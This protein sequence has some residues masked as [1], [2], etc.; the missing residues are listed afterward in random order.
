MDRR[1]DRGWAPTGK[2]RP[3]RHAIEIRHASFVTPEFIGLLRDYQIALVIA[4][5]SGKWPALEDL[6]ADFVYVRLHGGDEL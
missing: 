6:S 1:K 2:N 3:L 4:D 5:T